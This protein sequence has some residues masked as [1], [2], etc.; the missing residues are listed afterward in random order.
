MYTVEWG[1][2][3]NSKEEE[4]GDVE[5]RRVTGGAR[6]VSESVWE[7][8]HLSTT[9]GVVTHSLPPKLVS[10]ELSDAHVSLSLP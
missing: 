4:T 8:A 10:R 5:R 7:S 9:L 2:G 3:I 6:C 1:G